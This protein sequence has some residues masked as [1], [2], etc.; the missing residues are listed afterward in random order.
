MLRFPVRPLSIMMMYHAWVLT[1]MTGYPVSALPGII[2][3]EE[4][5]TGEVDET[6][7]NSFVKK[8]LDV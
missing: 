8:Q 5:I 2:I 4:I 1:G 6:E 7:F 3:Q